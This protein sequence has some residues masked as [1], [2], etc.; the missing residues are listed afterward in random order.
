[1]SKPTFKPARGTRDFMPEDMIKREYVIDTIRRVFENYGYDPFETPAFESLDLLKVKCGEEVEEQIYKFQDKGGRLLGLRFDLTVPLARVVASNLALPKPFRRYCI[2]RAWRY[3]R[4]EAKRRFREFWQADVDIVGSSEPDCEAELLAVAVDCL[5]ALGLRELYIRLNNR[6]TLEGLADLAGVPASKAIDVFRAIDKLDRLGLEGVKEELRRSGIS[7]EASRKIMD[8]VR[9]K[10]RLER[11]R[12]RKAVEE[13]SENAGVREGLEELGRIVDRSRDY[14]I[15]EEII[16]DFSLVR[17]LDYYTGPIFE[18]VVKGG[19]DVGSVAGG[20]RYDN[21]VELY[22][23]NP[24]PASG[25]SLGIERIVK[26]MQMREMLELPKTNVKV[27]V[28]PMSAS[29]RARAIEISQSLR[30][31]GLPTEV[32]V[33]GRK[34]TKQLKYADGKGIPLAVLVGENEEKR[35]CVLL[36]NL[37]KEEQKEVPLEKLAG[38]IR[39]SL[40]EKPLERRRS[41]AGPAGLEP[42]TTGSLRRS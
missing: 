32:D 14:C 37:W 19:E 18:I 36:K 28:A 31:E 1:M 39:Q 17:G 30:N 2:S 34:L 5:R 35:G 13:L 7:N 23:G 33:T 42:A 6:K 11:L 10:G 29:M 4:P 26:I 9:I 15:S 41:V 38:E 8:S 20:G 12:K 24:T 21:L 22:G 27:F 25:I 40:Q 3:E 16:I